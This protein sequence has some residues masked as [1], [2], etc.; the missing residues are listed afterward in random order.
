MAKNTN[1]VVP[2]R[3]KRESKTDYQKRLELLKSRKPRLVVRKSNK[4]MR[5]QVIEYREEGD[6]V[7]A[8]AVSKELSSLGWEKAPSNMP[9]AYLTGYLCGKRAVDENIEE[10]ITDTGLQVVE[11]SSR[12][13]AAVKGAVDAGIDVSADEGSFGDQSRISGEHIDEKIPDQ[14]EKI[15]KKID[16]S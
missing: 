3:R 12:V 15:K 4:H 6:E 8:D 14:I 11:P 1:Y 10:A 7:I 13:F 2:Y 9:A 16:E 5:V